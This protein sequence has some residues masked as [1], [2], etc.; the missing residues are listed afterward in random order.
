MDY[1]QMW[2]KVLIE[3]ELAI[4][5]ATFATWFH[6]THIQKIEDGTVYLS[7]P[8]VFAKDWLGNK[9]HKQILKNLRG[10]N[11]TIRALEY[12]IAKDDNQKKQAQ[13]GQKQVYNPTVEL[14]LQDHQ[15]NKE[16]N[17]NPRYTFETLV[18]GSFN[19]LAYAAS[20]AVIKKPG[21][22]YSPFFVYGSP[23]HG[24]THLIQAIGNHIKT[25]FPGKKVF[26][27]TSEKFGQECINALQTNKM[28]QF[29]ERYRKYDILIM[30]DVQFFSNKDKI[31]EELFHLFNYLHD[32][33]HQIIFSSDKHPNFISNL[34]DRL[35]SR[36]ASGMLV[37]LPY[38][39]LESRVAILKAK[40]KTNNF[41]LADDVAEYLAASIEGNIRE[42]EGALNS[43]ICQTQVKGKDLSLL[44]IKNLLK[45]SAKPKKLMAVKDIIKTVSDFYNIDEASI[46]DKT[47][48]KE[49]VRPR[50]IAMYI[51]REDCNVSYPSI[52]QKL[53]GRDHTTVIHS[54]EKIKNELKV[55]PALVQELGQIRA[56]L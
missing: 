42:L 20:Q 9:Y 25:S 49:V 31:Q 45:N 26:Y 54:C 37:E 52:G 3:F 1:K 8:S 11:E 35:R 38:P 6:S 5:R 36:F 21:Q 2:E 27:L 23:G 47:R 16:D 48:R 28:A 50:Q 44:E 19:E 51:L 15:I 40:S 53:G 43:I 34:E 22:A 41:H 24:K 18:V 32:N 30:D 4:S 17:L 39:D 55:D 46:Y 56:L 14:P 29:K 7:V 13:N 33:N 12:V 10:Q